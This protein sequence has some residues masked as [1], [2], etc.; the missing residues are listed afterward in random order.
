MTSSRRGILST[1]VEGLAVGL[2]GT[3]AL[4]WLSILLYDRE[5]RTTWLAENVARG[6]LHAYERA[7]DKTTRGKLS[8]RQLKTWGWRFH[9]TFGITSGIGY[10][11]L[12]RRYPQVGIGYGLA[13]G[14]TFFLLV[15]ELLMPLAGFT[16][17]PRAFSWK[18]HARGAVSHV[19]YGVAAEATA[20]LLDRLA[21]RRLPRDIIG[22]AEL[23]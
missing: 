20:R 19:A 5:K 22:D 4:D 11:A 17:G 2:A 6:G 12:R 21:A 14:A 18:V 3:Q 15:D 9:K 23:V 8:R 1:I 7:L 13:F 10:V 16:P